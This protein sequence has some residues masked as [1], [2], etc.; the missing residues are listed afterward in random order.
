MIIYSTKNFRKNFFCLWKYTKSFGE[1]P[2]SI[3]NQVFQEQ[4]RPLDVSLFI[5][6]F[7]C[8]SSRVCVFLLCY[9]SIAPCTSKGDISASAICHLRRFILIDFYIVRPLSA[10]SC[11][12]GGLSY[13]FHFN[14]LHYVH[15]EWLGGS[16]L[17]AWAYS[18]FV[19]SF[20]SVDVNVLV[21]EDDQLYLN[22]CR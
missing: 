22:S 15:S 5:Y 9:H 8:W 6:L 20:I 1:N 17:W 11:H 3:C 4:W 12:F 10:W 13:G 19:F 7:I 16:S 14:L 21:A 2:N 18:S